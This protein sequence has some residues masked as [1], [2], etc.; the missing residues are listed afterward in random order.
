M[1]WTVRTSKNSMTLI[2]DD[3]TDFDLTTYLAASLDTGIKVKSITVKPSATD[4]VVVIKNTPA[5]ANTATA[6]TIL[7]EKYSS[8][9][10]VRTMEFGDGA[11]MWPMIDDTDCTFSTAANVRITL[12]LA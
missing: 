6:A 5:A 11:W 4:D 3:S 9:Y 8:V 7:N 2:P 10:D 12:L 1:A